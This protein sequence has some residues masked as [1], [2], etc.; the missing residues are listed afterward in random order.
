MKKVQEDTPKI[1]YHTLTR[2]MQI[3]PIGEKEDVNEAYEFIRN[4]M[5]AFYKASNLLM[6]QLAA[7]YYKN[8]C[9]LSNEKFL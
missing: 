5:Y 1:E 2:K 8:G 9:D 4:G 3:I 7:S 6:G